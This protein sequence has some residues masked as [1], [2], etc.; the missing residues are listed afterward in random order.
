MA[1]VQPHMSPQT[2]LNDARFRDMYQGIE[3]GSMA[4]KMMSSMGWKEGEGLGASKQGISVHVKAHKKFDTAGVGLKESSARAQD[5]TLEMCK[6]SGILKGL[7]EVVNTSVSHAKSAGGEGQEKKPKKSK[8]CRKRIKPDSDDSTNTAETARKSAKSST[9]VPAA[10]KTASTKLSAHSARYANRT[11][12]KLV[13]GYSQTDLAAI[14][15]QTAGPHMPR[16]DE[17]TKQIRKN[18]KPRAGSAAERP[19]WGD[20]EQGGPVVQAMAQGSVVQAGPAA[21]PES[22]WWCSGFARRTSMGEAGGGWAQEKAAQ[23]RHGFSEQDQ[24]DLYNST[25]DGKTQG[26]QGLGVGIRQG[27]LKK[28]AWKGKKMRFESDEEDENDNARE[29]AED[30]IDAADLDCHDANGDM[31]PGG[32]VIV[33]AN[34][35]RPE[36]F[37]HRRAAMQGCCTGVAAPGRPAC[38]NSGDPAAPPS[39]GKFK[40][41]QKQRDKCVRVVGKLLRKKGPSVQLNIAVDKAVR[42]LQLHEEANAQLLKKQVRSALKKAG[43]WSIANDVIVSDA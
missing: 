27:E 43:G 42:T 20:N 2:G 22:F 28:P 17:V 4:Y 33:W 1:Q 18:E 26:K 9:E 13:K 38:G 6:F 35:V 19:K 41:T 14:L 7:Q 8:K 29:H 37:M 10:Q 16:V 11:R 34:G 30:A 36:W 23:N 32:T 24:T 21:E 40:L 31:L 12:N 15:G 5:W 39:S 25:H 3:K